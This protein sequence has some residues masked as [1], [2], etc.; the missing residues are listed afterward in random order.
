MENSQHV[1]EHQR[2]RREELQGCSDVAVFG[3][4]GQHVGRVVEDCRAGEA[5][6]RDGKERPELETEEH[7]APMRDERE[8][9]SESE[10]AAEKRKSSFVHIATPVSPA[11]PSIVTM[12]A[13]WITPG[14]TWFAMNSIGT[15]TTAWA[16]TYA[17]SP[18]YCIGFNGTNP[19]NGSPPSSRS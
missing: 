12:P 14:A 2:D 1:P 5:D 6:H 18:T 15:N 17:S 8:N 13:L 4:A 11:K 9:G 16:T 10:H 19:R 3:E 7:T